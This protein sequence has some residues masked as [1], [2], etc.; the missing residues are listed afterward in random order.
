[1]ASEPVYLDKF[2]QIGHPRLDHC[3]HETFVSLAW[4]ANGEQGNL[5]CDIELINFLPD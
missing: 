4:G 2:F 5:Y 3:L 1:M